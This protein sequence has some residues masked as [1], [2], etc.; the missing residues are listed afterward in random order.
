MVDG[1]AVQREGAAGPL[2]RTNRGQFRQDPAPGLAR[3]Q[4]VVL[5][6]STLAGSI[7]TPGPMVEEIAIRLMK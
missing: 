5:L 2:P 1:P 4:C 7:F 6:L 3:P